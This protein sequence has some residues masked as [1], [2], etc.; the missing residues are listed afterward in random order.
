MADTQTRKAR[1]LHEKRRRTVK[2]W[3]KKLR[4]SLSNFL[5]KQSTVGDAPVLDNEN[6]PFLNVLEANWE[7]IRSEAESILQHRENIPTFDEVSPDQARI[8]KDKNWRTYFLFGFRTKLEKNCKQAPRT[9]QLLQ[10]VPGLQTAWFSILAP[11]YH[12]PAH[13][14][15][16]RGILTAH[17]GLIIPKK[18]EQCRM[19]V[20]DQT[21]VWKPGKSFVFCDADDH[22]VWND[23]DEERTILLMQFDRPMKPLGRLVNN[24]F[25]ALMKLT[26]FYQVPKQNMSRLEDR[27]EAAARKANENLE[28]MNE[29]SS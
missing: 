28:K 20:V 25:L 7:T 2:R 5:G 11:G 29:P 26:A 12:I 9:T 1:T 4:T 16:S 22:E 10:N 19:R 18:S 17:L 24:S 13:K 23:T 15:V 6:F 27:F 21:L 14:G 3:G 8:S